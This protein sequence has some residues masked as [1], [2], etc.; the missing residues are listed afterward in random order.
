MICVNKIL[1]KYSKIYKDTLINNSFSS[2]DEMIYKY[3]KRLDEMYNSSVYQEHNVYPT[4]N[5]ELIYAVIAMC[6][7]LKDEGLTDDEIIN[8]VNFAFEKRRTKFKLLIKFIDLFPISYKIAKKWN[9][10][11]HAKRIKDKSLN[12]DSFNVTNNQIE[13]KISKCMYVEIFK[14]FGIRKLCKIF[15]MT[16]EIA[17]SCLTKHVNFKRYSDLSNGKSCHDVIKKIK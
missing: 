4:M 2:K 8:N 16:D 13:Y 10:N 3:K 11:D 17:Y 12:Y 5:V 6:L 7:E 1:N 15:C 9:L 14:Y